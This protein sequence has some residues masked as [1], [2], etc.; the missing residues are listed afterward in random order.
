MVHQALTL[1]NALQDASKAA[2]NEPPVSRSPRARPHATPR[3]SQSPSPAPASSTPLLQHLR[4]HSAIPDTQLSR[5]WELA[6]GTA[7]R[8]GTPSLQAEEALSE[9]SPSATPEPGAQQV[10]GGSGR[11][12]GSEAGVPALPWV[13]C[14]AGAGGSPEE[15]VDMCGGSQP[16]LL[17]PAAASPSEE[18]VDV[19]RQTGHGAHRQAP[20]HPQVSPLHG[21]AE[22]LLSTLA[23]YC[24]CCQLLHHL[25]DCA[26]T[27]C[28]LNV[29]TSTSSTQTVKY[30]ECPAVLHALVCRTGC[31]ASV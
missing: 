9:L 19:L 14:A 27:P 18:D 24:C 28:W 15:D 2:H 26:K 7:P 1:Q 6:L 10:W 25:W 17:Q 11:P 8:L 29:P 4:W 23:T 5:P 31:S 16:E 20:W 12:A 13:G 21:R 30:K 22:T 3:P